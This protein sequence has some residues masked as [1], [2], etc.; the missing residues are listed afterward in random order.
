MQKYR[1]LILKSNR[2][3]GTV[4]QSKSIITDVQLNEA[5]KAL[6]GLI[7]NEEFH[8]A[9]LLRILINQKPPV[10]ESDV[11]EASPF[12]L[13][14]LYAYEI[15][16]FSDFKVDIDLCWATWTLPFHI[17]NGIYLLASAH[18]LCDP[19]IEHWTE[20]LAGKQ[21]L[22]YTTSLRSIENTLSAIKN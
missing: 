21:M 3:L 14:D 18:G 19:V 4:L 16:D 5:N 9:S 7:K 11:L 10:S 15:R 22:W 13:T 12:P 6:L 17:E 8:H 2:F 1:N 20:Y